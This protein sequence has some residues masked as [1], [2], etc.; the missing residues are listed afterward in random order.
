M[1]ADTGR[2]YSLN[3]IGRSPK[4]GPSSC[5][6]S[7]RSQGASPHQGRLSHIG[8]E[9][10]GRYSVRQ[11]SIPFSGRCSYT[12]PRDTG[13]ASPAPRYTWGS[14]RSSGPASPWRRH[15]FNAV[16]AN[17]ATN[18]I[19]RNALTI[20]ARLSD[21]RLDL[22]EILVEAFVNHFGHCYQEI[23]AVGKETA[24]RL[25][26][27]AELA[28]ARMSSVSK[29][30]AAGLLAPLLADKSIQLAGLSCMVSGY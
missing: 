6:H 19:R 7:P 10:K 22:H 16:L 9:R 26:T 23:V 27:L 5:S 21:Q 13:S 1:N 11:I 8:I 17:A 2:A 20:L 18:S 24:S 12:L 25:P 14:P 29:S 30:Q 4:D 3:S 15:A 28:F